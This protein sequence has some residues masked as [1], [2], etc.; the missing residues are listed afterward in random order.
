MIAFVSA[1]SNN[2]AEQFKPIVVRLY[3]KQEERLGMPVYHPVTSSVEGAR[4]RQWYA[5]ARSKGEYL[6]GLADLFE[7]S[8]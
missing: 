1:S 4:V 5:F 3:T 8:S 2:Y 6:H 7:Y